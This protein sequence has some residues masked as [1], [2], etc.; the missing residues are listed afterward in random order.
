MPRTRSREELETTL[1]RINGRGY[2][3]YRDIEGSYELPSFSLHIDHVQ[4]DPFAAPSRVR[5]AL[6][7]PTTG[8][9]DDFVG[10]AARNRAACDFL[11]R[12]LARA[13]RGASRRV[14]TGRGGEITIDEP[15]Q[16][17]LERSSV[18]IG[19][20]EVE[21]RITIGLPAAGRRVLGREAAR[22]LLE[23]LPAI[24]ETR[25]EARSIDAAALRRHVEAVEDQTILRAMLAENG[26]VAFVA[27]GAVLPRRSG[28]DARPM[29]EGAVAFE[30]PTALR[31]QFDLPGTGRVTGLGVPEGVTLIVGGGYHGKSTLLSAIELGVYDHVP[32]D[33]RELTVT[34]E[35]A[36][37]IRAED[38]RSVRGVD[39]S[40]FI[41][42]L[43]FGRDTRDF[44]TDDAS[45]STSQAANIVE[46]IEAGT[47]LLL[48]DEDTSATNFMIRDRRM[49]ELIAKEKEP[50]T[51]F[52]DRVRQLHRELGISTVLVVGGVGDYFDV[53][54]TVIA[55]DSYEPRDVTE[56]AAAIARR[57][58]ADR[59]VE[60]GPTFGRVA[61]RAPVASSLDPR[62]GR[63]SVKVDAKGVDTI[64]FGRTPLDLSALEQLV[65]VS[66]TRAIG[67]ALVLAMSR[68]MDDDTPIGSLLDRIER[69]LDRQGLDALSPR[70]LG[71]YARP[72]RQ[73]IAAALNRLRTLRVRQIEQPPGDPAP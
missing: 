27:D 61:R 23:S 33:G 14:G 18:N 20:R 49:Q 70:R 72:R 50:I 56:N 44:S 43:P 52:I 42:N 10:R 31:R 73:E 54:D 67:D 48:I 57:H 34:A 29:V 38:G 37:V 68:F 8:I 47:S 55:M 7:R 39:I 36:V 45:G 16:E 4:G 22:M 66:Q 64:L 15:G 35:D 5:L 19:D 1:R 25:L 62:R 26:L 17:V 32:G 28:V 2:R 24:V 58:E 40:P 30:S 59:A 41:S 9:G 71:G 11:T 6:P 3:A 46:A 69:E 51:P 65:S 21:A 12:A 63:R 53:A 60:S 13:C